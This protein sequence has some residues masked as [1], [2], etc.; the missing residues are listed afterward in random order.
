MSEIDKELVFRSIQKRK[1]AIREQE[2]R[3][4]EQEKQRREN[5]LEKREK[6]KEEDAYIESMEAIKGD[7]FF[8]DAADRFMRG[9]TDE[10][11]KCDFPF[12]TKKQI[13]IEVAKQISQSGIPDKPYKVLIDNILNVLRR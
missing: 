4:F 3:A 7:Y 1:E 11:S 9:L 13:Q 12:E 5:I 6:R 2:R 8:D 10:L